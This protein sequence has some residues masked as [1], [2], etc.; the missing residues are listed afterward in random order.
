MSYQNSDADYGSNSP[1]LVYDKDGNMM[2]DDQHQ[3]LTYDALDRTQAIHKAGQDIPLVTYLYNGDN[4]QIG[5]QNPKQDPT[6]FIYGQGKLTNTG[7]G[8]NTTSYL[9]GGKQRLAKVENLST[10]YYLTDQGQSV[11]HLV[12]TTK[13]N[14][15][16]VI[17]SYVYSPYGIE[18]TVNQDQK[19]QNQK[20]FGFDGQLTDPQTGW[21]FLG[22][23][24]RAYNPLLH[25]FMSQDSMSP[26]DKGGINGYVFANNNP[27]MKFD[28]SGH[29]ST[30]NLW[31]NIAGVAGGLVGFALTPITEGF[32]A[33]LPYIGMSMGSAALGT[34]LGAIGIA[35]EFSSD[36]AFQKGSLYI[37]IAATLLD[38][39]SFFSS[40]L[41]YRNLQRMVS[42]LYA[43]PQA[44]PSASVSISL[45]AVDNTPN[46]ALSDTAVGSTPLLTQES[47]EL[48]ALSTLEKDSVSL[49]HKNLLSEE[50]SLDR[51]TASERSA[52]LQQATEDSAAQ[53]AIEEDSGVQA[54]E[55]DSE[56]RQQAI[57]SGQIRLKIKREDEWHGPSISKIE[58]H[59]STNKIKSWSSNVLE[60]RGIANASSSG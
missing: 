23:G 52:L 6:Y 59:M 14:G 8:N 47:E 20:L 15:P 57:N 18:T 11:I 50:L 42:V 41:S 32:S 17:A 24:Y 30:S 33:L 29:Y 22:K 19:A 55:E 5:T 2:Q 44:E 35:S 48:V 3:L 58:M 26:F 56:I 43:A 25:R 7:Q 1:T 37:G 60:L 12:Q 45:L 21:Q 51:D 13:D 16:K 4:I 54:I 39:A 10:T 34:A 49:S 40:I 53:Q 31:L 9:Y 28:P 46:L 36:P 27:I 38:T